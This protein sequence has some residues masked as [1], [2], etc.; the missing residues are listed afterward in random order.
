MRKLL[1]AL[2][3]VF[4]SGL[5]FGHAAE[6][7]SLNAAFPELSSLKVSYFAQEGAATVAPSAAEIV[8][9]AAGAQQ[10]DDA[11]INS[12]TDAQWNAIL[13]GQPWEPAQDTAASKE[14]FDDYHTKYI[15]KGKISFKTTPPTFYA[16][17]GKVFIVT[18]YPQWLK[19]VGD[20]RICVEGYARQRDNTNEFIIDKMLPPNTLDGLMPSAQMQALQRDPFIVSRDASK[21]VMGNIYWNLAHDAAGQR[22]KDAYG[23]LISEWQTGVAINPELLETA[24]F[25]K[26][27]TLKPIRYGDHGF[28]LFKFK[29][30]GVVAPDGRSTRVIVVSLDAYYKDQANMSYSPIEALKGHYLVYYSIQAMER[31]SE[32]KLWDGTQSMTLYPLNITHAQRVQLLENSFRKSTENNKGEVYSLFYNSCANSALSLINSVLPDSRKIK[33]GWLPEVIYRVKA[34]FPDAIAA[35]LLKKGI[36]GKPLPEMTTA[37]YQGYAY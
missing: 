23:N 27:T 1:I 21:Y 12:L 22:L 34:T 24:Y 2:T 16:E 35:L 31:Y 26:K 30:G 7:E 6:I 9:A 20:T 5:A 25:V 33:T 17:T 29:P 10:Q 3:A 15:V 8:P 37:N 36:A 32:F 14:L 18:K 13:N 4:G 19:E 11:V 28:L